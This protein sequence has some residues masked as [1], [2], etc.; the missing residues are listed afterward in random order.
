[1]RT[2]DKQSGGSRI[3]YT[4]AL[5]MTS[6]ATQIQ[7]AISVGDRLQVETLLDL[8]HDEL[9]FISGMT[10]KEVALVLSIS[11]TTVGRKWAAQVG[12]RLRAIADT[13]GS[14]SADG[15]VR[16]QAF[17]DGRFL[18]LLRFQPGNAG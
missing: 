14:T 9:R 4:G 10:V 1:M 6:D 2:V 15:V 12:Q 16:H 17:L 5:L 7:Q 13:R 3:Q 8:V 18:F 11:E